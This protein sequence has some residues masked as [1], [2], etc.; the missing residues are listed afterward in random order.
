MMDSKASDFKDLDKSIRKQRIIDTAIRIFQQKGYNQATLEDF[1]EELGITK[2]ALYHYFSSK[3]AI[4]SVIYMQAMEN[5]FADYADFSQM[6]KLDL[7][8]P[9]KLRFFIRNHIQKVA[10]DNIAMLAV[11]L[12]EENQLPEGDQK[13]IRRE[14]RRYNRVLEGILEEG[15]AQGYFKQVNAQLLANAILGMCNSLCRW[16]KPKKEGYGSKE[17]MEL[18]ISLL[19]SGYLKESEN[20]AGSE[21]GAVKKQQ[22]RKT[23][24]EEFRAEQ[25]RHRVILSSLINEL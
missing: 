8:P 25:E 14:K 16:Y 24:Q 2:G 19:E 15:M 13:I 21:K 6:A 3:E 17:I 20:G 10:I 23:L 5:Y 12:T 1:A 7:S 11:F 9:D 4:L 18:F 22:Y